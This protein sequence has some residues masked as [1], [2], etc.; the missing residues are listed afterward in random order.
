MERS[1]VEW[2]LLADLGALAVK[3]IGR[4]SWTNKRRRIAP[5]DTRNQGAN[6]YEIILERKKKETDNRIHFQR[7][8]A[9][10][11]LEPELTNNFGID[12]Y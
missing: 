11:L 4:T 9:L 2:R 8:S 1:G 5:H 7:N 10:H 6:T 3:T 12:R